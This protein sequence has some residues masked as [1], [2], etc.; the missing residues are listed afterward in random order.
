MSIART[1]AIALLGL[2][3]QVVEVEANLTNQT[4]EISLIGLPDTSLRES[5]HRIQSA[6]HNSGAALPR[7][8]LVINLT[9]AGIPKHGTGFDLAIAVVSM[10]TSNLIS[11]E[12]IAET[13]HLGELG[14]DGR[15]RPIPGIL[16]AVR[17]ALHRGVKRVVVPIANA[18]EASLVNGIEVVPASSL[19]EVLRMYGADLP[20]L[21][22]EP[23]RLTQ[24][25]NV[26]PV[27]GD[28]LQDVIGNSDAIQGAIV[29]AAG[30][31]N[32]LLIGPPGSGKSMIAQRFT[33]LLPDLS[34]EQALEAS[35]LLSVAGVGGVTELQYRPPLVAPHHS[36]TPVAMIGGGSATIRPGAAV[37]ASHGVLFLDEATE[38]S[39][40]ALDSLRQPLESGKVRIHRARESVEYP[41]QFQLVL[42][43]N[44]CP[45]GNYS[46]RGSECTCPVSVRRRYLARLSG[47]LLDRVDLRIHTHRVTT[48]ELNRHAEER[49]M[50]TTDAQQRIC[51]ARERAAQRLAGTGWQRNAE[52]AG[53]WL[54][55]EARLA[56]KQTRILDQALEA[57]RITMRGYDRILRVSW[58]LADLAGLSAPGER[59]IGQAIYLRQAV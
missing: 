19:N 28:D 36:A 29:A 46:A 55:G 11:A 51:E 12:A 6:V 43:T 49:G 47:P 20:V 23:V 38:F 5:Q 2:D 53:N 30:G 42:A 1:L 35:C 34:P 33:E 45:C 41:A 8:R 48:A 18:D 14:L 13:V 22:Y 39:R 16:P 57:G 24:V 50:S 17:A 32:L 25:H 27:V 21:E 4:P 56:K 9:P 15:L 37:M 3:G 40:I 44:P 52:I 58:T 7:R 26:T 54:R 10:V 31:H 59:E